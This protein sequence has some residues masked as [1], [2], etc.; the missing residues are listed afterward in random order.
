MVE[1]LK[2][3]ANGTRNLP[4]PHPHSYIPP[5]P[6]F[7]WPTFLSF[8]QSWVYH[9]VGTGAFSLCVHPHSDS[10]KSA[11]KYWYSTGAAERFKTR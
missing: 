3:K 8:D 10:F 2:M 1:L 5:I 7:L 6:S 4:Y 9:R 11:P